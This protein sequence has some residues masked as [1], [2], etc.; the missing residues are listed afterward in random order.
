MNYWTIFYWI[1][2]SFLSRVFK[3]HVFQNILRYIFTTH[4]VGI[5]MKSSSF[6]KE[7]EK[8]DSILSFLI[9]CEIPTRPM[10]RW[11]RSQTKIIESLSIKRSCCHGGQPKLNCQ[12]IPMSR[13][14]TRHAVVVIITEAYKPLCAPCQSVRTANFFLSKEWLQAPNKFSI[15]ISK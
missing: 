14:W 15:N 12:H 3:L 5:F 9:T 2:S 8:F 10:P 4:Q 1:F 13:T 6:E 7:N 11:A